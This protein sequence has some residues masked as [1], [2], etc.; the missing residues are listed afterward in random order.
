MSLRTVAT[1]TVA[2]LIAGFA[3]APRGRQTGCSPRGGNSGGITGQVVDLQGRPVAGAEVW[4][5]SYREKFGPT[6]RRRR[7]FRLPGLK[8]DR[9]VTVWADGQA[10]HA[11]VA[12]MSASS[13]ARTTTSAGSRSCPAPGCAAASSTRRAN[14]IA[15][16]G[17]KLEL[18][19]YR[20]RPHDL[21][22]GDRV[23]VNADGDGRFATPPLPAGDGQF[24]F[25]APGKVRTFVVQESRAGNARRR[26]GRCRA[27][28]RDS[29]R[30]HR[31]RHGGQAGTRSRGHPRLRL[32]E[33]R[34]DRQGGPV[35]HAR[36]R[37]GPQNPAAP[38]QR[39]LQPQAVRRR[40]GQTD[41][42]LTVIK[43]YEI[44]GTAVDAETGKPV[45]IDTVRL[46]RVQRDPKD[47]HVSLYG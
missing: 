19:R 40:P 42:K 33:L 22:A 7:R 17:V 21:F 12:T 32:G 41:L 15:G 24:S 27:P 9:P 16:A 35:H 26:P 34:K 5:V 4:G 2:M 39:L 45:K 25:S 11:S 10:W 30:R 47:G 20:A 14:P 18:Y 46:C 6:K 31:H 37:K 8:P 44:H 3:K 1:L 13:P 43:A 23:D 36:R 29:G 28:G 38:V